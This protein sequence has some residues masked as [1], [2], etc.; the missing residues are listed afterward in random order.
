[1]I[2]S[3]TTAY[4][5]LYYQFGLTGWNFYR[6]LNWLSYDYFSNLLYSSVIFV[7]FSLNNIESRSSI[8]LDALLT[9]L[10]Y[11]NFVFISKNFVESFYNYGYGYGYCV[12]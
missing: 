7:G 10:S 12:Y 5:K 3:Y 4:L 2:A 11:N 1:M 8:V 9:I 6:K